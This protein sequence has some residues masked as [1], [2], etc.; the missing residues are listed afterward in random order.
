MS[1]TTNPTKNEI[2]QNLK[3]TITLSE[4]I[5]KK[6]DLLGPRSFNEEVKL[7]ANLKIELSEYIKKLNDVLNNARMDEIL[8]DTSQKDII[9]YNFR[10]MSVYLSVV[11]QHYEGR[12]FSELKIEIYNGRVNFATRGKGKFSLSISFMAY[13][14]GVDNDLNYCWTYKSMGGINHFNNTE[15]LNKIFKTLIDLYKVDVERHQM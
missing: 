2:L 13:L 15:I 9:I 6:T 14:F 1:Y 7:F 12:N 11:P 3:D 5:Q 8:I 4:K 10:D